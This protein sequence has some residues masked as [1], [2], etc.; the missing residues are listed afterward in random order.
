[1]FA[2]LANS[3][4]YKLEAGAPCRGSVDWLKLVAINACLVL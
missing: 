2:D 3:G 1:M 4:K